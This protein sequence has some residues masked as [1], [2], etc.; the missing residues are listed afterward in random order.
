MWGERVL[1]VLFRK[2]INSSSQALKPQQEAVMP[3]QLVEQIQNGSHELRDEL[4]RQYH[5]YILKTTSRFFRRYIDP[6]RDDAYSIALAA[7]DEA[8]TGF[9]PEGGRLFLGFAKTVI[10]R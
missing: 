8:I 3:E 1:L 9:S 4:I 5:P 2:W 10:N 7:F 6:E